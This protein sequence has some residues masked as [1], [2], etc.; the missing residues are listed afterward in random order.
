VSEQRER[1]NVRSLIAVVGAAIFAGVVVWYFGI[2]VVPAVV[3]G[4]VIG[5]IGSVL[6]HVTGALPN[7]SWPPPPPPKVDGARREASE[8]SWAL[9][10]HDGLV[11]EFIV[12]RVRSIAT[13][14]LAMRRLSLTNPA[15]RERIQ[16]IIGQQAYEILSAAGTRRV[17]LTA[18]LLVLD[19][20]DALG[21]GPG[22][23][24]RSSPL[25][26]TTEKQA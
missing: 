12:V 26:P 22:T 14:R 3:V 10:T 24:T 7:R 19:K 8:L 2:G 17:P 23:T 9:Q 16:Q 20:L 6:R 18:V 1:G 13:N 25:V 11:D 21:V 15:H 4:L 5:A